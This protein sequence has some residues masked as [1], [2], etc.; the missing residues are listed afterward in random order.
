MER[1]C[2][3]KRFCCFFL[4]SDTTLDEDCEECEEGDEDGGYDEDD[5]ENE[6]HVVMKINW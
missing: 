1:F 3:N 4:F 6:R 2:S 5:E